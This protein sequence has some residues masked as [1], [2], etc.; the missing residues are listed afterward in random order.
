MALPKAEL[1]R[2]SVQPMWWAMASSVLLWVVL[3]GVVLVAR[4]TPAVGV[5]LASAVVAL[6]CATGVHDL[7]TV[8]DP[9]VI[10]GSVGRFLVGLVCAF[11]CL[12]VVAGWVLA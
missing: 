3:A 7:Q 12:V 10:G 1:L 6:W 5:E 8:R 11:H 4:Q 2:E 9:E